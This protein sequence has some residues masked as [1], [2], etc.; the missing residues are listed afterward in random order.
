MLFYIFHIGDA[1]GEIEFVDFI[2]YFIEHICNLGISSFL[3]HYPPGKRTMDRDEFVRLF[4]NTFY[5]LSVSKIR[6]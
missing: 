4:K 5:F 3:M 6:D 2:P 1:G